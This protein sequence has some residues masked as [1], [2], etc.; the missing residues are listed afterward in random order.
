MLARGGREQVAE[1]DFRIGEGRGADGSRIGSRGPMAEPL[2]P[3]VGREMSR[4]LGR[5]R[6]LYFNEGALRG[7]FRTRFTVP[8]SGRMER[9]VDVV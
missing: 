7:T 3:P 5:T 2:S 8:I 1:R 6:P 4:R 9:V